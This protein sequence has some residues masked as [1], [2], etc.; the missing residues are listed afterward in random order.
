MPGERR[1][2]D[3]G[4]SVH[5]E[6]SMLD[7]AAEESFRKG[8]ACLD[9]SGKGLEALALFEAAVKMDG[10]ARRRPEARYLSYY[11][12]LLALRAGETG[13]GLELCRRAAREEFYNPDM[14]LNL[15]RVELQAGNRRKAHTAFCRGL[16]LAPEHRA[17]RRF[18]SSMGMRA[19]PAIPFLARSNPINIWMGRLA[20]R[21]PAA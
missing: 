13:K 15:G 16:R 3:G 9:Q 18:L 21:P 14:W 11:G 17:L 10:R 5:R 7:R 8:L 2:L 19:R 1:F 6:E 12:M 4:G 20:R